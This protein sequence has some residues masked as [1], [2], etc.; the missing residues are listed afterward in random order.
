MND[1]A[2]SDDFDEP[3]ADPQIQKDYE[4]ALG[5]FLVAFNRIENTISDI[6]ELSLYKA[7]RAEIIE[8][9]KADTF[10]RKIGTLDLLSIAYPHMRNANLLTELKALGADRNTLAHGHFDQNPF[11]GS[12]E[13]STNSRT[14]SMPIKRITELTTRAEAAWEKLRG[15][16]VFFWFDN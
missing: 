10:S 15:F 2:S 13:V 8:R 3:S 9:F 16:Q 11:D 7:E 5:A 6:I 12:Y 4:A 14:Q 1:E